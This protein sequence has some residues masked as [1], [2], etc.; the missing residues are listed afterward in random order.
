[1]SIV[2][3]AAITRHGNL[4]TLTRGKCDT[5]DLQKIAVAQIG[6]QRPDPGVGAQHEHAVIAGL[7]GELAG[8]HRE[9]PG[10]TCRRLSAAGSSGRRNCRSADIHRFSLS[11]DSR[12]KIK[13]KADFLRRCYTTPFRKSAT[14]PREIKHLPTTSPR[15]LFK[16]GLGRRS[17][18]RRAR[19]AAR[20]ASAD[21]RG[22]SDCA[23]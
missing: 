5:L 7:L 19:S 3:D 22:S 14:R 16:S 1:M 8:S 6:L 15:L 2:V 11:D 12:N 17:V 9:G 13:K 21:A 4:R 10:R 20:K 18:A 23:C